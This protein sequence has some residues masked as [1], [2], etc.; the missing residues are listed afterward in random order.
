MSAVFKI[1]DTDFTSFIL[2]GKLNWEKN[3]IDS[4][5]SARTLDGTMNRRRVASKRKM[6]VT[7]KRLTTEQLQALC[8][9]LSPVFVPVTYLDPAQGVVTKT[10]YSSQLT[11]ATWATIG[12][13]T[14]WDNAKFSL[15]ER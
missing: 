5:S 12:G 8:A 10:F 11:A 6:S 7:C 15:V 3:D 4:S 1:G 2:Q 9:A 14:Y 13:K